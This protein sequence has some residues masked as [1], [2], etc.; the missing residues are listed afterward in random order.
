M[1]TRKTNDIIK[2]GTKVRKDIGKTIHIGT[3]INYNK[4]KKEY[5]I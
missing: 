1:E 4:D 3:F 5:T 2:S